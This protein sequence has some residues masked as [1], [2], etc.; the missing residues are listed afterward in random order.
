MPLSIPYL[1][2]GAVERGTPMP[3][4]I[5]ALRKAFAEGRHVAPARLAADMSDSASLLVMPAWRAATS[6]G[7]KVVEIDR[8]ASP[9]VRATYLLIDR[10]TGAP[11]A[12][13]DGAALTRRRTA[14]ASVLAATCLARPESRR[15]L[16]IGTGAL[17]APLIEAYASAFPIEAIQ[18]WGRDPAKA[19]AAAGAARAVGYPA[20]ATAEIA[21]PSRAPTSSPPPP[22]PPGR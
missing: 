2:A 11:K 19:E 3:L 13:F 18:I 20:V 9:A 22:F 4:L 16:L 7:V 10:A 6:L 21:L 12:L 17:N 5:A 1:D 14:A 15:L 8:A